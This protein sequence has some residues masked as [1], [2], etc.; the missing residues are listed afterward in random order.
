MIITHN[1]KIRSNFE[2][3]IIDIETIGDFLKF[4]DEDSRN[5]RNLKPTILGYIT[6]DELNILCAKGKDAINELIEQSVMIVPSLTKPLFA[7]QSM[8]ERGVFHH[9]CGMQIEFYG[10]LNTYT[11]EWK[12]YACAELDIPNYDDPFN[13]VGM[14][15]NLAWTRGD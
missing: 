14:E 9:T 1:E 11:R 6:K 5:Y 10:E 15:C 8:F 7:F 12:G 3:T 4:P 13:N 2:G